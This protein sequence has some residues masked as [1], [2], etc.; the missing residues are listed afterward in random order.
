MAVKILII[1]DD[2]EFGKT[3]SYLLRSNNYDVLAVDSG[4]EGVS[5]FQNNGAHIILIDLVMPG[6]TGVEVIEQIREISS[7]VVIV[8][9]SGAIPLGHRGAGRPAV[10]AG[11]DICLPKPFEGS[12]LLN[13]LETFLKPRA[14]QHL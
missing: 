7:Q 14:E 12:E 8:A 4:R 5:Q 10:R 11:A 9:M 1:D 2:A 13:L 3:V 6:T